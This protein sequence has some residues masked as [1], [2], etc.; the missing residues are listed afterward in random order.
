MSE[1][2]EKLGR[3]ERKKRD[4]RR[5]MLKAARELFVSKGYQKTTTREITEAADV[6]T[7][8]LFT[9]FGDKTQLLR[10]LFLEDI[11]EV[12]GDVFETLD[13]EQPVIDQLMAIFDPMFR[14]YGSDVPLGREIF[15]AFMFHGEVD[16][17][18]QRFI[19]RL[20]SVFE[21][22]KKAGTVRQDLPSPTAAYSAF[23][24]YLSGVMLLLQDN[25]AE[26]THRALVRG[27]LQVMVDGVRA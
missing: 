4:K 15:Q 18:T 22:G 21:H 6:A 25:L 24:L 19:M 2:P 12:T 5:R 8:T 3:R 27:S 14:Y 16:P 17:I 23:A 7:G 9:Y 10:E 13:R 1:A 26:S 20:S 11:D